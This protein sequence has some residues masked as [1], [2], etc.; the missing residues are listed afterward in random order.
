LLIVLFFFSFL[1]LQGYFRVGKALLM[2]KRVEEAYVELY[3]GMKQDPDNQELR[4]VFDEVRVELAQ[5]SDG[6]PRSKVE[7]KVIKMYFEVN[8]KEMETE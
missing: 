8:E 2:M 5:S 3:K 6:D 4:K 7:N 1:H